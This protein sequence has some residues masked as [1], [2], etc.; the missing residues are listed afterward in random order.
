MKVVKPI[1]IEDAHLT[2]NVAIDD[3][4]EWASG[5]TYAAGDKIRITDELGTWESLSGDNTGNNPM[6]TDNRVSESPSWLYLGAVNRWKMFDKFVNTQTENAESI[7]ITVS[8]QQVSDSV[9]LM[10][11]EAFEVQITVTHETEGLVYDETF[12]MADYLV[13]DYWEYF[14]EPYLDFRDLTVV[15][16]MADLG[17]PA[18][19][20]ADIRVQIKEPGGTAKCGN[21]ILGY[22]F[23]I[24]KTKYGPR[25]SIID[26]SR[27]ET[28]DFGRTFLKPGAFA[29]RAQIDL[30]VENAKVDW[31]QRR[32]A[33]LR[34]QPLVWIGDPRD[35]GFSSLSIYGFYRDFEIIIPGPAISSC[36]LEIEGLI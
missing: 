26:Y 34:A 31:L 30:H 5:T 36:S 22:S 15:D 23:D 28:D 35:G 9:V 20:V 21:A 18:Y 4:T 6:T 17:L 12:P 19:D 33:D 27:K 14:F 10:D 7:D 16:I 29:K 13:D 3:F 8:T 24:G 25:V 11:V 32:L 1:E 2:S